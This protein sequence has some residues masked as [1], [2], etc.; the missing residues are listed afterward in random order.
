MIVEQRQALIEVGHAP[1]SYRERQLIS[2]RAYRQRN[3][4]Q[5]READSKRKK[6]YFQTP[7]GKAWKIAREL[8]YRA[9][10]LEG[11]KHATRCGTTCG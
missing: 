7:Q 10:S 4:A 9:F 3:G 8:A 2:R 5:L 11:I 1:L 6:A